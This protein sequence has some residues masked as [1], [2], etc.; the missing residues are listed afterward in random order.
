MVSTR[1]A[2]WTSRVLIV[3]AIAL[4]SGCGEDAEPPEVTPPQGML[5]QEYP[6][7]DASA[8]TYGNVATGRAEF[9][10]TVEGTDNIGGDYY[11]RLVYTKLGPG[12]DPLPGEPPAPSDYYSVHG[13]QLR[14]TPTLFRAL[15]LLGLASPVPGTFPTT[16]LTATGE[17]IGARPIPILATY[18][19]LDV[20]ENFEPLTAEQ[21]QPRRYDEVQRGTTA[22]LLEGAAKNAFEEVQQHFPRRRLWEFPLD[23]GREWVVFQTLPI[24]RG[25]GTRP[26]PPVLAERRVRDVDAPVE[27]PAYNGP[28]VVVDEWVRAL[29]TDGTAPP[30]RG[31]PTATYWLAPKTGLVQYTYDE[32]VFDAATANVVRTRKHFVLMHYAPGRG[33]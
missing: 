14:L 32:R 16:L 17:V 13:L 20:G 10:V 25:P 6:L 28:A 5:A 4:V 21:R 7:A 2:F 24:A 15:V 31:E 18:V 33:Q 3:G 1:Q 8:W 11:R 22:T 27:T 26:Q 19:R 12:G 29:P 30:A 9:R 23:E